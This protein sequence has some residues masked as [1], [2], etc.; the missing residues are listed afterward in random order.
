MPN[1]QLMSNA[2]FNRLNVLCDKRPCGLTAP[3][4]N[5]TGFVIFI[6]MYIYTWVSCKPWSRD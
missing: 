4:S 6:Y 5:N 1:N 3:L 2:Q